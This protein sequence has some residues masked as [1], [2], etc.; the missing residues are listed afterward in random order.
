MSV[1]AFSPLAPAVAVM[2]RL[3]LPTKLGMLGVM[4]LLPLLFF[5]T[6]QYRQ[7]DATTSAALKEHDGAKTLAALLRS[8]AD[9]QAHRDLTQ[10]V[11]SNDKTATP[12]REAVRQRLRETLRSIDAQVGSQ[13]YVMPEGWQDVHDTAVS[14]TEGRHAAR[15]EEATAEHRR[16]V[17]KTRRLLFNVADAS[18][19]LL[20]P[21]SE[22]FFLIDVASERL[23]PFT[24]SLGIVRGL[25]NAA[26]TRGEVSGRDRVALLTGADDITR[27][28]EEVSLRLVALERI[29]TPAP[30]T[31]PAAR[32]AAEQLAKNTRQVFGSDGANND[33]MAHYTLASTAMSAA[34]E[35]EA[36]VAQSLL[37]KLHQRAVDARWQQ[38]LGVGLSAA[39]IAVVAYLMLAF[40]LSFCG[41]LRRLHSDVAKVAQGDLSRRIVI[42]GSDEL[43][44]IGSMVERMNERLSRMVAEVRTC[45]ARV[46]MAGKEVADGSTSL[47]QRTEEQALT[48]RQTLATAKALSQAVASNAQAAGALDVLIDE[49]VCDAQAGDSAMQETISMM[50]QLEGSSKRVAEIIAVIDG[51]AFQT[52]ILA[53]NAAVEAARAGESGRGFAVVAAEVRQLARR[54]A[55]AAGEIRQLITLSSEQVG[56]SVSR[57][58]NV[59]QVL[60]ALARGVGTA[61]DS[62]R[63]IARASAQQSADLE[64]VAQGMSYLDELT[65]RNAEMVLQG[66]HASKDLVARAVGLKAM[67]STMKL[68]QGS[69][70]EAA[71]LVT[72]A[73]A[74]IQRMGVD[75]AS[76]ELHSASSGLVDRDLYIFVIDRAGHYRVHGAKP[77]M[78]GKRVHEV[79]GVNGDRFLRD[80][81]AAVEGGGGWINYDI[82]NPESG[83]VQPKSSYVVGLDRQLLV[84]CGVYRH[85]EADGATAAGSGSGRHRHQEI[86]ADARAE[87]TDLPQELR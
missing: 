72:R 75:G 8:V 59:G 35:F 15:R 14:F 55:H 58:G 85:V 42:L 65:Q 31:W 50:V 86:A 23:V 33:P 17:E 84:G 3:R 73:R 69:A 74:L 77:A 7:L 6:V 66:S 5:A 80:A 30:S 21:V 4:A 61:S 81:W 20:D 52:N 25:A 19:L 56:S 16:L 70:D 76:N 13:S 67:V 1:F 34:A 26:L 37:A 11:L 48:L 53:L 2:R 82:V 36:Q 18:G 83:A 43:A 51:I 79:P 49:L 27:Q 68:R 78:E 29:G 39:G 38:W 9:T 12:E 54:S 62:L 47:S 46:G 60:A 40:Y 63:S 57:I 71:A 87:L 44:E 22:T 24:E 64:L 45:A 32:A 28:I 41:A 10:R